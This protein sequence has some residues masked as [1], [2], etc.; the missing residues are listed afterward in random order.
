MKTLLIWMS[1]LAFSFIPNRIASQVPTQL[2]S[3]ES[4]IVKRFN[5]EQLLAH[6]KILSNDSLQ[7]RRTATE[8]AQMA[9]DYITKQLDFLNVEPLG[10]TYE[11]AFSFRDRN[12]SVSGINLLAKIEG[13]EPSRGFIV[14]SAHYDHEG[15]KNDQIYNGADDDASG[16]AGLLAFA[17]Y[18]KN[19]PS[20]HSVILAFFDAEELGLQGS[21]YYVSNPVIPVK[22]IAFNIN[23]DMVSRNENNEIY[24]VGADTKP[25]FKSVLTKNSQINGISILIGHD[26]TDGKQDW[27]Y[28]SDH[29]S[30]HQKGIP[31]LYFG[32]E[33]HK[34]YHQPTD[35]F[36]NIQ[37]Q[38][39]INVVESIITIFEQLDN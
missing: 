8:G 29:G 10:E 36:E 20:R 4:S 24:V 16:V 34:D 15:V 2:D 35:D 3:Q 38:F 6:V 25:S 5:S 28:S 26:G 33:D 31:F 14:L 21:K 1:L 19:N 9:R 30:F 37:P 32:V 39:F 7:G 23:L 18:F 27:T 11:Q 13:T 17:D 22:D 12:D